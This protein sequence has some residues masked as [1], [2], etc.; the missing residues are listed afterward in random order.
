MDFFEKAAKDLRVIVKEAGNYGSGVQLLA[1]MEQDV[2]VIDYIKVPAALRRQ[3]I[4]S[5]ILEEVKD[6]AVGH[7]VLVKLLPSDDFGTPKQVLF[8]FYFSNGFSYYDDHF[9]FN[10]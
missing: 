2:I 3:G 1:H 8:A 7:N 4:A 5:N 6:I 9:W 10:S